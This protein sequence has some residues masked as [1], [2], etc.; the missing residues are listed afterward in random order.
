MLCVAITVAGDQSPTVQSLAS[1]AKKPGFISQELAD[2][3]IDDYLKTSL[4]NV[5]RFHRKPKGG[6]GK[7][8]EVEK[9]LPQGRPEDI[10]AMG[11]NVL[12][13]YPGIGPD[14]KI[15]KTKNA[16][17]SIL[18]IEQAM[19]LAKEKGCKKVIAFSRPAQ[20]RIHLAKALDESV[21]LEPYN[22][23]EFASF[24]KR[25]LTP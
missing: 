16:S 14:T 8:G 3:V 11:Y 7:G 10:D 15:V 2:R 13:E 6:M 5:I 9:V 20:F 1:N 23:E 4:D 22:A 17:P 12:V 24:T 25:V 18:L 19:Q 21:P